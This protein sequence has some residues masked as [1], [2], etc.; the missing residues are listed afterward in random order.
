M[1]RWNA[2]I[3]SLLPTRGK[4]SNSSTARIRNTKSDRITF[5]RLFHWHRRVQTLYFQNVTLFR[6]KNVNVIS[7][8]LA[9][10]YSLHCNCL[11]VS[12]TLHS[13]MY[14]SLTPTVTSVG[15]QMRTVWAEIYL[16]PL[17]KMW[18]SLRRF[19]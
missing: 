4:N 13:S 2:T 16:Q 6:V 11:H 1:V 18:P 17:C 9:R 12:Q 14:R 10:Q 3:R 7:F 8:T 5:K 15:Q 19:S